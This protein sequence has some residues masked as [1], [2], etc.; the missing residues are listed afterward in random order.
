[1]ILFRL[2]LGSKTGLDH[3]PDLQL[4]FPTKRVSFF[5]KQTRCFSKLC[6]EA[7]QVVSHVFIF[8]TKRYS[9]FVC[10]ITVFVCKFC[11]SQKIKSSFISRM[12]RIVENLICCIG[13]TYIRVANLGSFSPKN[14]NSGKCSVGISRRKSGFLRYFFSWVEYPDV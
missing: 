10:F 12:S 1:M 13:S 3:E 2:G 9:H 5:A 8:Y 4:G 14:A 6:F 11:L 7:K